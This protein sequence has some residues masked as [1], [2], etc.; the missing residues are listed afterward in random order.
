MRVLTMEQAVAEAVEN[1]LTVL[2]ERANIPV[3]EA[4]LITARL[5]PN[6]VLS[7]AADHLDVL[8]TRFNTVNN[9]GPNE[10]NARIDFLIERA[11]KREYRVE[12]ATFNRQI[13][14]SRLAEA[15]RNLRLTVLSGCVDLIQAKANLSLSQEILKNYEELFQ[16]NESRVNAGSV[17]P[18]ELVRSRVAMLQ[19]RGQ[20]QKAQLGVTKARTRLQGLLGPQA[21]GQAIDI[22][23][24]L[25]V[26]LAPASLPLDK[27]ETLAIE[28][29]P[30]LQTVRLSQMRSAAELKLQIANGKVDYTYGTEYRRQ[31]GVNGTS[32]SMGVFLSVPLPVN[33]KNQGEIARVEAEQRLYARQ[34][35]ALAANARN[36]VRAAL[37]AFAS[38]R[39]LVEL[40]EKD[41]LENARKARDTAG[42]VYR[43]GASSLLE[44]L[45]AQRA[46]NDTMQSYQ[47]ALGDYRRAVVNLNASVNKEIIE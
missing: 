17:S 12:T 28:S 4:T 19:F 14:E 5:K 42:Y 13:A 26:P 39:E 6:P 33:N 10:V 22:A 45:D 15:I 32:N 7:L 38:S 24:E 41:L 21:L 9:A 8:G 36:E 40:I 35:G 1:N 2:A 3:A 27:L 23:G 46:L 25:K 16:I 34:L 31:Q 43:A 47:E 11:H 30:E 37:D 18:L 44:F 29:R 20:V